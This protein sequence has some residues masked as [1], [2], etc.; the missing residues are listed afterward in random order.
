MFWGCQQELYNAGLEAWRTG[1][2]MWLQNPD[3]RRAKMRF[4]FMDNCKTLTEFAC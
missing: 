3:P 1:Y 4:S 2:R